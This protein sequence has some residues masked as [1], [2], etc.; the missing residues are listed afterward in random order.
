MTVLGSRPSEGRHTRDEEGRVW[1]SAAAGPGTPKMPAVPR[2][3]KRPGRV[4]LQ[5]WTLDSWRRDST[6]PDR[7][8]CV[9]AVFTPL[10]LR[11]FVPAA[12]RNES[13]GVGKVLSRTSP[14]GTGHACV[15]QSGSC[16]PCTWWGGVGVMQTPSWVHLAVPASAMLLNVKEQGVATGDP[17]RRLSPLPHPTAAPA[18]CSC[19]PCAL[20]RNRLLRGFLHLCTLCPVP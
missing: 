11:P 13:T 19:W 20:S 2:G 1:S 16:P 6:A 10:S 7:E 18:S 3:G 17:G 4:S 15:T 8:Q 5:L 12:A 9:S 14:L